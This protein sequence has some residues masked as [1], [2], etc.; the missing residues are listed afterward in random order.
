[1]K[2]WVVVKA[3]IQFKEWLRSSRTVF[4]VLLLD[5]R[6]C[7]SLEILGVYFQILG[8]SQTTLLLFY[9]VGMKIESSLL[10]VFHA[11]IIDGNI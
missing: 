1:M 10:C 2:K 8:Q 6:L 4:V 7:A 11:V 5:A 9:R 3:W